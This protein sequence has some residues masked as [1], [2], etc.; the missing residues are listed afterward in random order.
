MDTT[1]TSNFCLTKRFR[2]CA[3]KTLDLVKQLITRFCT[4]HFCSHSN[5]SSLRYS[6]RAA[7]VVLKQDYME[8][9]AGNATK[10]ENYGFIINFSPCPIANAVI[11][12]RHDLNRASS[13]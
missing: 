11:L 4:I 9:V 6:A 13:L 10:Y 5:S 3:Q 2:T 7:F 8:V 12:L 1:A